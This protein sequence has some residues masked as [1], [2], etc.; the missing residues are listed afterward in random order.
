MIRTSRDLLNFKAAL[1]KQKFPVRIKDFK[2][3]EGFDMSIK[4]SLPIQ[5][6]GDCHLIDNV[7]K[8]NLV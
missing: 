1:V 7:K 8:T 4:S 6:P 2:E 5:T 3:L